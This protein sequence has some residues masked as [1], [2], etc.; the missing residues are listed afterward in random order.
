MTARDGYNQDA[1]SS[2]ATSQLFSDENFSKC[3]ND[4]YLAVISSATV[5]N[6][7]YKNHFNY[8]LGSSTFEVYVTSGAP[9]STPPSG[10]SPGD[11]TGFVVLQG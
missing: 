10:H 11:Y 9:V 6:L 8:P 7:I 2:T 5:A 1:G 3:R 4:A